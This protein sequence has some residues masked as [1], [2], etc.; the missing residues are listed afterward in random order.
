MNSS[1][2]R[3]KHLLIGALATFSVMAGAVTAMDASS[4]TTSSPSVVQA[5]NSKGELIG[6]PTPMGKG[7]VE[8]VATIMARESGAPVLLQETEADADI[9]YS[10][11]ADRVRAQNPASAFVS[12]WPIPDKSH[13]PAKSV[14]PKVPQTA[15][16]NFTAATLDDSGSVPPDTMGAIGPQ[17]FIAFVNGRIRSFNKTTGVVDGAINTSGDNFFASVRSAGTSDPRIRFDRLT[18]RWFV[19]MIDVGA[20]NRVLVAVSNGPLITAQSSFT[21][22]QFAQDQAPPLGNPGCLMDYPSIGI[23]ANAIYVGGNLF[24]NGNAACPAGFQG[25]VAFVIQK[26]SV[27]GVGPIV[28]SA[29]RGLSGPAPFTDPAQGDSV[30]PQGVDN[31]DPAA[32]DGFFVAD[33]NN[34]AGILN[35]RRVSNP[36]GTPTLSADIPIT[37]PNNN[38]PIKVDHLGNNHPGSTFNGN[39]DG[40]DTRPIQSRIVNGSIYTSQGVACDNTG[41][42]TGTASDNRDGVRFYQIGSLDTSPTLIQAGTIFDPA[43]TNPLFYTYG[44]IAVSGQG[45]AALSFTS[46]GVTSYANGAMTGR[47]SSD[48]AGFTNTPVTVTAATVPY[49]PTFDLGTTRAR[50]WGD[51]SAISID[52]DDNMTLWGVSEYTDS[53]S[54]GGGWGVKVTQLLAPAPATPS[55]ASPS[56][57][58]QGSVVNVTING[59]SV[60]GTGFYDPGTGFPKHISASV[61][62][63]NV[64]VL[65]ATYSNAQSVQLSLSVGN[66]AA[67]GPRNILIKNPDGQSATG[68]GI[69]TVNAGACPLA[70]VTP[71]SI[72]NG[73]VGD[74]YNQAFAVSGGSG[75]YTFSSSGTL[76]G[77]TS[78]SAAGVLS[79]TLTVNG[80]FNFSIVASNGSCNVVRAYTVAVKTNSLAVVSGTPQSALA[81]AAFP[82]PLVAVVTDSDGNP[83]SGVPVTFS[84]PNSGAS[85]TFPGASLTAIANTNGIGVASSPVFTANATL[86]TY[87]VTASISGPAAPVSYNLSNVA[88]L[89]VT[90]L[91]DSGPGS[92]RQTLIDVGSGGGVAFQI[93]LTGTITLT[94]GQL[95]INKSVSIFGPG[96]RVITVSGNNAARVFTIGAATVSISGLTV[97]NGSAASGAG[98]QINGGTVSLT[99]MSIVNNVALS[100]SLGGGIDNESG[101]VVTILRC[102]IA[103][104]SV[105]GTNSSSRGG[106]IENQGTSMTITNSTVT[107]NTVGGGKGG[108]LRNG[109]GATF[110]SIN[111]TFTN[112]AATTATGAGGNLSVLNGA[113]NLSNTIVAGGTATTHPDLDGAFVSQDYNL[114][115]SFAGATITGTTTNNITGVSPNLAALANNGGQTDTQLPNVGSPVIDK[116]G[117]G[118]NADQRG[119]SRPFD[120]PSITNATGGNGSDIGAVELQSTDVIFRDGFE[121]P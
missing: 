40:N 94:T 59:T 80:V 110:T 3:F 63:S 48:P 53:T 33:S 19:V 44:S 6:I 109:G 45:H 16:I 42:S 31:D 72:P 69:F 78:L 73:Q 30:T 57:A 85:G 38:V 118:V 17:Q 96:A 15:G 9:N 98:I 8:S 108:A 114:L 12:T 58:V 70:D 93:G 21:F 29:F 56:F 18:H 105:A 10:P 49:N 84:A 81:N 51:Y 24:N 117:A 41:V 106:G 104:N 23:D 64:S 66:S 37:V 101:G 2:Y 86:G 7:T 95:A 89:I 11:Y 107:G 113:V 55:S 97:S 68:V 76:P 26:S 39:L 36:G 13:G 102:T 87:V 92:L 71:A 88:P 60:A 79:G 91:N 115:Q 35:L 46:V 52:P 20:P 27:L 112:N 65:S 83:V 111:T 121:G 32:T 62:G 4:S 100:G 47:L 119:I 99:D 103:N 5:V 61:S 25:A 82:S 116:G 34:F 1:I 77:G 120:D 67:T 75:T 22:F 50:R 90:N 74:S 43:A 28:V 14:S 54:N